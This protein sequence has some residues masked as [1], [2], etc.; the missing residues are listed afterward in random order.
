MKGAIARL[1]AVMSVWVSAGCATYGLPEVAAL[2]PDQRGCQYLLPAAVLPQEAYSSSKAPKLSVVVANEAERRAF[3]SGLPDLQ[4]AARQYTQTV[5]RER[6]ECPGSRSLPQLADEGAQAVEVA[7]YAVYYSPALLIA[8][9]WLLTQHMEGVARATGHWENFD[10]ASRLQGALMSE[11][12]FVAGTSDDAVLEVKV[13][14]VGLTSPP[15]DALTG[16]V[17]LAVAAEITLL[18]PHSATWSDVYLLGPT[19]AS[20][21]ARGFR[22]YCSSPKAWAEQGHMYRH[23]V[24]AVGDVVAGIRTRLPG[25]PWRP[26]Q[27]AIGRGADLV[28]SETAFATAVWWF[29][30]SSSMLE[31]RAGDLA[32]RGRLEIRADRVVFFESLPSG[33][34]APY[35]V[36][37]GE[38]K[39]MELVE[40][41]E[42]GVMV[43][44][45]RSD[46]SVERFTIT[47]DDGISA[48]IVRTRAALE[49]LANRAQWPRP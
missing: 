5:P 40:D 4:A 31:R 6:L 12:A 41:S 34:E 23:L 3:M 25:L 36:R 45:I 33:G 21:D 46:N 35:E 44:L 22:H 30:R 38:I 47:T 18:R 43:A 32:V 11:L 9:P 16:V 8:A 39:A 19:L 15:Y 1:I 29:R 42:H 27:L 26:S 14:E 28:S 20:A 37:F 24:D 49:L 10:L 13:G 48:D 2:P 7:A 17:C